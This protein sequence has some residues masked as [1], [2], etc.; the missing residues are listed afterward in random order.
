MKQTSI[1]LTVF[2]AFLLCTA[3]T[4]KKEKP[5]AKPLVPVKVALA[6]QRDMPVQVKAIGNIEAFTS[7]AIKSQ[8]NGQIARVHFQEGRDVEKGTMLIS[9]DP[10]PFLATLSQCEAA[11]AKDQS[12]VKFAC[13]SGS[14]K[15][16]PS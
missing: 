9:I 16:T 10:E 6:A 3:C 15:R 14:S 8:V 13:C 5:R 2:T 1:I 11:L 7:V 12:Q 4:A